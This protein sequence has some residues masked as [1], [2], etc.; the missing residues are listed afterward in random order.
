MR[1]QRN[2]GTLFFFFFAYPLEFFCSC[3]SSLYSYLWEYVIFLK[4]PI[5]YLSITARCG[6]SQLSNVHKPLAATGRLLS[7]LSYISLHLPVYPISRRFLPRNQSNKGIRSSSVVRRW[8][9]CIYP[10][11]MQGRPRTHT[12]YIS[13]AI[14]CV[15]CTPSYAI[16]SSNDPGTVALVTDTYYS[17]LVHVFPVYTST[18]IRIWIYFGLVLCVQ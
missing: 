8:V 9:A 14:A 7:L 3:E 2:F 11:R 13:S 16:F 5:L 15:V 18:C 10:I 12:H 17:T 1:Q 6:I 4:P